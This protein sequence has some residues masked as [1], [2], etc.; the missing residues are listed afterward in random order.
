MTSTLL[1]PRL[2]RGTTEA[3][4]PRRLR[5]LPSGDGYSL[6]APDGTL[7]FHA[8]G[9]HGRHRCLQFARATGSLTV[10]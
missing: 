3:A 8:L 10:L 1:P 4:R 2:E 5:L 9:V 7:V 6:V